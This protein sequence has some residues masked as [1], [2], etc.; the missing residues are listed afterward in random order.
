ML[1]VLGEGV[2]VGSSPWTVGEEGRTVEMRVCPP[3]VL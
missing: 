3:R 1:V 2:Y